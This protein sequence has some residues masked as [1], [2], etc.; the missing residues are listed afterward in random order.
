MAVTSTCANVAVKRLQ[1]K[2]AWQLQQTHQVMLRLTLACRETFTIMGRNAWRSAITWSLCLTLACTKTLESSCRDAWRPAMTWGRTESSLGLMSYVSRM[3][4]QLDSNSTHMLSST[5]TAWQMRGERACVT[6]LP[7]FIF[8]SPSAW[9]WA[10]TR[11]VCTLTPSHRC[12]AVSAAC[13][14]TRGRSK[15]G[16]YFELGL[17]CRAGRP[18]GRCRLCLTGRE[19]GDIHPHLCNKTQERTKPKETPTL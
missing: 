10:P 15:L 1:M 5:H 14:L 18:Y 17:R 9:Q 4:V 13:M 19:E 11:C 3:H 12:Y 16:G 2:A 6:D 7:A 8:W